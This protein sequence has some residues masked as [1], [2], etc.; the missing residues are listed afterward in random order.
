M[1]VQSLGWEDPLEE[2]TATHLDMSEHARKLT[3][4]GEGEETQGEDGWL[5]AKEKPGTAPS[6]PQKEPLW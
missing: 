2:K 4:G 5:Q 1:M 3:E 6:Q